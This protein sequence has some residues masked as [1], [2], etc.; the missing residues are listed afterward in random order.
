M[1]AGALAGYNISQSV[2]P[3]PN[4]NVPI[5]PVQG[6][7]SK[8]KQKG[9]VETSYASYVLERYDPKLS[10]TQEIPELPDSRVRMTLVNKYLN[11]SVKVR[12]E[13]VAL[14]RAPQTYSYEDTYSPIYSIC[15]G[16]P[17][18]YLKM[19]RKRIVLIETPQP[20]IWVIP[21][22]KGN[23]SKFLQYMK[24]IPKTADG[25]IQADHYVLFTDSFFSE[26][27]GKDL[28]N[29]NLYHQFLLAKINNMNNLYYLN[30]LTDDFTRVACM[31]IKSMYAESSL[32]GYKQLS[33]FFEPDVLVFLGPKILFRNS[34]LPVGKENNAVKLSTLLTK[35]EFI[36]TYKSFVIL[37]G[38]GVDT[39]PSEP[40][41]KQY[42]S[43]PFQPTDSSLSLPSKS[44][45]LCPKGQEC[46]M[47][48]GGY[49][50]DALAQAK[51]DTPGLY[52]LYANKDKMPF[53]K[54]AGS[55]LSPEELASPAPAIVAAPAPAATVVAV[56]SK[57]PAVQTS[58]LS[59]P[60]APSKPPI[61]EPFKAYDAAVKAN[62][63]TI[64]INLQQFQIRIP[65]E[66]GVREEWKKAQFTKEEAELLNMLQFTPTLLSDALGRDMWKSRL[67][68]FLETLVESDCFESTKLLTKRECSNS[69]EFIKQIHFT[70]FNRKLSELYDS[71]GTPKPDTF[72]DLLNVLRRLGRI[73][74]T[75]GMATISKND[76]TGDL[77][78]RFQVL[79]FNSTTGEYSTDFAEMSEETR[80]VLERMKLY[81]VKSMNV[82]EITKSIYQRLGIPVPAGAAGS[83][84]SI[85]L[86][87]A[88]SSIPLPSA[89]SST[90]LP[91][92][93]SST[94]LPSA[95]STPLPSAA[96]STPLPSATAPAAFV[97]SKAA[98][99]GYCPIINKKNWCFINSS[100]QMIDDIPELRDGFLNV[101]PEQIQKSHTVYTTEQTED[102]I[103]T[104]LTI[105]STILKTIHGSKTPGPIDFTKITV[106][107]G[108]A[109]Y[110]K[111]INI[112]TSPAN[113][114]YIKERNEAI[115]KKMPYTP[116]KLAF[117][118][119][120]QS[121]ADEFIL[122]IFGRIF[123]SD[124]DFL[125]KAKYLFTV[126][127]L[128]TI[129][130]K[131]SRTIE[132]GNTLLYSVDLKLETG[133]DEAKGEIT[134][135]NSIQEAFDTFQAK[136]VFTP[137]NN[138]LEACGTTPDTKGE[139]LDKTISLKP[140]SFTKY[141]LVKV[142]RLATGDYYK[143]VVAVTN[144]LR[145]DGVEF[146]PRGVICHDGSLNLTTG[147]T[148]GHYTYYHYEKGEPAVMCSDSFIDDL[149]T[150]EKKATA[151]AAIN[152]D[153]RVVLY[154]RTTAVD[155]ALLNQI[156]PIEKAVLQANEAKFKAAIAQPDP[157]KKA[158]ERR[159]VTNTIGLELIKQLRSVQ[160]GGS[161]EEAVLD[162]GDP[163]VDSPQTRKRR[164]HSKRFTR[165]DGI[166][167]SST[168][169]RIQN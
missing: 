72:E 138:Q 45:I 153:V 90:P 131:D 56:P 49:K 122:N 136:E 168:S 151:V 60:I 37:P 77:F 52:L 75:S 33:A 156:L 13:V 103:R 93:A 87:A 65:Y 18:N 141:L 116:K 148:G 47:F 96:S 101:T 78:E 82:D 102:S 50:L 127:S 9:G 68:D 161:Q 81:R 8:R 30:D 145:I 164:K 135:V 91:S 162:L 112:L 108:T 119:D 83:A 55:T 104:S 142:S 126:E 2:L 3:V 114:K 118:Y 27:P 97:G 88:A 144:P 140:F 48:Q 124:L 54:D 25:K 67:A 113:L 79:K 53:L 89:A 17:F 12:R 154:E 110:T 31:L 100:I 16:R 44:E 62:T 35:D 28:E 120:K 165:R 163:I 160:G 98:L 132:K 84:S 40:A 21:N 70:L 139:A 109:V 167:R 42:F 121:D 125:R 32:T 24:L 63:R 74:P 169:I 57:A 4:I 73:G 129:T 134:Y 71:T 22:L 64:E 34:P 123:D 61:E 150:P 85:P 155:E 95:S 107:D 6:G 20:F 38:N 143:G 92:A 26:M 128:D 15:K 66:K 115:Q 29:Q 157:K 149:T 76:Y 69:Q 36:K 7:G 51:L 19:L 46:S 58:L 147:E 105:F 11:E 106:P 99:E 146:Q 137:G 5:V 117:E 166:R 43:L 41:D 10:M 59:A 111:L 94:P 159:V 130:C 39:L 86:P 1:E 133:F 23:L 14:D 158:D 80:K 152:T